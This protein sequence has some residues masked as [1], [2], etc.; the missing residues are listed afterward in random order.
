MSIENEN[1]N[2]AKPMLGAVL[3]TEC[4]GSG[5]VIGI[6]Y[7]AGCCGYANEDGS[8]CNNPIPEQIQVQEQCF[9][10]KATGYVHT[11]HCT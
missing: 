8:C 2:F 9:K 7:T 1:G 10:C 6:Q 4:E 3:C 11:E 5:I